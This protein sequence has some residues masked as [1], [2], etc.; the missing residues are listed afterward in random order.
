[1]LCPCDLTTQL[2]VPAVLLVTP[3]VDLSQRSPLL[4]TATPLPLAGAMQ[5]WG[6]FQDDPTLPMPVPV[7]DL[8]DRA[9][10]VFNATGTGADSALPLRALAHKALC[11]A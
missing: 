8:G 1:M 5:L 11:R 2:P 6:P 10:P 9:T 7:L 3:H 4:A